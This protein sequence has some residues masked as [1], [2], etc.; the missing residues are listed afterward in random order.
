MIMEP[1]LLAAVTKSL[2]DYFGVEVTIQDVKFLSE[3]DRR[4]RVARL[5]LSANNYDIQSVIFKQSLSDK[6]QETTDADI[7]ARFARDFVGL[8]FLSR[9]DINHSIPKFLGA[10]QSFRF[11]L[12]ED[13]GDTH[14][15]L[16]DSLTKSDPDKAIAAL[17]RFTKSLAH[18]HMASYGRLQE[19][20]E[21][22]VSAHPKRETLEDRI[23]W[24]EEDLIP[25]LEGVCDIL[26]IPCTND[27]KQEASE[28]I[29]KALNPG[30]FYVLTHGDICPDNVFDH[31]DKD[32]LRL[33][34]FEWV[35]PGSSLLD[36]TYFR[37]NFPTC[38]CAK[39][40]PEAVILELESLYRKTIASKIK[41]NLDDAKYNKS[42]VAACGFWLLSSMPFALRIMDKDKCWPSGPVP[43]DSLW[44]SEDN[45]ARPR[46]ISRLQGF[47]QI[48]KAHGMLPHLRNSAEQMLAKAYEKWDDARPLDLYPAF[49]N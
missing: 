23:K 8:K 5:F 3:P 20:D 35:R 14:I 21:L 17:K 13:L 29:E 27:L 19:Y 7:L 42:Y 11:I 6:S 34:D 38:W 44:N 47:I 39:A 36:A 43:I 22:L 40:L 33:I 4:N 32:E 48:S 15:S 30:K 24:N 16:V 9:S 10:S 1:E 28:V 2:E 37:M 41:A 45:L 46:F 25:K 31:E 26:G 18:F 12:L 49:Q